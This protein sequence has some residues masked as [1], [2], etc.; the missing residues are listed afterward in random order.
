MTNNLKFTPQTKHIAIKYHRFHK[1]VKTQLNPD[2]FIEIKYCLTEEQ[3]ADIFMKPVCNN[4]FYTAEVVSELV[5]RYHIMRK[6]ENYEG[7]DL[8]TKLLSWA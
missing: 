3:V 6:C 1:H 4:I 2:G 5:A 7:C 8:A